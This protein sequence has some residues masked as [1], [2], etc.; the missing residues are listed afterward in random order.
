MKVVGT[1]VLVDSGVDISCIN[2]DFVK[3]HNLPT[4][5]LTIPIWAQNTDHSCNKIRDIQYTYDL[6]LN[7]QG[8][9]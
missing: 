3:K 8:L 7:I 5:K 2:Q 6:F 9:I 1:W 4:M